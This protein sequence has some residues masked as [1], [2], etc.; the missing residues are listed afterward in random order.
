MQRLYRPRARKRMIRAT[1]GPQKEEKGDNNENGRRG[2]TD[3]G[4]A[5]GGEEQQ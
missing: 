3:Q 4:Q 1:K 5:E 2:N